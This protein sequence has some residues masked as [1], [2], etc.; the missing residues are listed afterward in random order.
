MLPTYKDG[1]MVLV[2]RLPGFASRLKHGDVVLVR[3]NN[4][5]LI[6]RV[7]KLPGEILNRSESWM[8]N[9]SKDYFEPTHK[10][11][12]PLKVPADF[13][14]V[15]GDNAAVSDDSRSFGPVAL[16][17]VVGLVLNSPPAPPNS[18]PSI[19]RA[20]QRFEMRGI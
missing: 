13:I 10:N 5:I 4:E 15:L 6:K 19:E 7:Y 9:N 2:N 20:R 8:F 1:Q 16:T 11:D 17:D 14:V 3:A 12:A 18:I